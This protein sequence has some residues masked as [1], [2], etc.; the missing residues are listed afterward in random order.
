MKKPSVD[1]NNLSSIEGI[2]TNIL[3]LMHI[4]DSAFPIGSYTQS[5]GM[6]TYIQSNDIRTKEELFVFLRAFVRENL[7]YTDA[8]FVKEAYQHF[9][10]NDWK[11]IYQLDN[12]CDASKNAVETREASRM[13]G[14]QFLRG[15]LP[16]FPDEGLSLWKEAL[17]A[18]RVKGHFSIV[19]SLY[20]LKM[21]FDLFT[22]I[23]TFLYSST[24]SLVHNGIRAIPLGQKAGIEI[25][26]KL[27]PEI[28]DTARQAME[29]TLS[30]LTNHAVG[31]EIASM[32]HAY[33]HSRLF[34]S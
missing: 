1:L 10:Q 15:I 3:Y 4:H 5:F 2:N 7:L 17:D 25:I 24:I 27:I 32:Q 22:T 30:D 19:Y 20:T 13:M 18:G 14:K 11:A 12:I 8:I 33:L 28:V 23:L 29:L 16:V 6:E 34:I 21:D 31:L 9:Q 26:H